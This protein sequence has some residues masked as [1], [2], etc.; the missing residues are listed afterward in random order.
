MNI[1]ILNWRD[2]KNP[3][4]GGAEILTHELA[5]QW[6]KAGHSVT[7][8][9]SIFPNANKKEIIDKVTVIREGHPDLRTLFS[10]VQFKAY[11]YYKKNIGKFDVIID[12]VHGVPF[13]TPLYVKEPVISLICEV[14]NDIWDVMF[15]FPWSFIGKNLEKAFF[16]LYTK[17]SVFTIS[18]STKSD[19]I[20]YGFKSDKIFVLPMGITRFA[21]NN[22][23]KEA[24]S[25]IIFVARLNKMK[26][27][28]DAIIAVALLKRKIEKL[29]FWI[30]GRGEEGYVDKL[31]KLT[32]NNDLSENVKF[33][34]FVSQRKKF[35]LM[36]R[37]HL[38]VVPSVREGFGMIVPEAGSVGTP[39]VVYDSHGLRD[40]IDNNFNGIIVDRSPQ[41]LADGLHKII[42]G[43]RLYEKICKNAKEESKKYRWERTG[44]ESIKILKK[45]LSFK[46]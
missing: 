12:E 34:G 37:S 25:T 18:N 27:I 13:F 39:A 16:R 15:S 11:R 8:F 24:K 5:K 40:T 29:S 30:I 20:S 4:S 1:L 22:I 2:V 46:N 44:K 45:A 32:K 28:E 6:I 10:S 33:F 7:L 19:L 21:V 17:N 42:K 35:E 36:A 23:K 14:A 38:I 9:T 31:K 41:A 43:K 3:L 26:G